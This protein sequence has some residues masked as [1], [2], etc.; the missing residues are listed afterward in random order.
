MEK[1]L[2]HTEATILL[3]EYTQLQQDWENAGTALNAYILNLL[4]NNLPALYQLLY[5]V[6]IDERKARQSFGGDTSSIADKLTELI[7]QRI[8]EKAE[9]RLKY[10]K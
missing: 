3:N 1:S 8:L 4:E 6:D 10:R 9:S 7:L 2:C 5:K